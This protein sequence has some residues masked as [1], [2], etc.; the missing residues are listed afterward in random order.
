MSPL[1]QR[2]LILMG[3]AVAILTIMADVVSKWYMLEVLDLLHRPPIEVTG[4]FNLVAVWNPGV[5][6]GMF[7]GYNQPMIL[8][9]MSVV[10][11]IILAVWL[12]R[13]D[14]RVLAIGLGLVIGGAIGNVADRLRFGKVFDFLDFH[15]SGW[16]WPAFNIADSAIFIGVVLLCIHSMFLEHKKESK[17]G[18]T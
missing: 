17:E 18:S 14:S 5:S 8:S 12:T 6:F 10:I 15:V 1:Q 16:H 7:A 4:Y 13:C 3:L 11:V 9:A 2:L